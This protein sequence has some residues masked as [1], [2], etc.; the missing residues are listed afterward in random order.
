MHIFIFCICL[1]LDHAAAIENYKLWCTMPIK[2]HD[3]KDDNMAQTTS[4]HVTMKAIT[5]MHL[6]MIN[7]LLSRNDGQ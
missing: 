7:H 6:Y 2:S 4:G 3:K 5:K 1:R